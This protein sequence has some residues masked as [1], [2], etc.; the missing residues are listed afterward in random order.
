VAKYGASGVGTEGKGSSTR[1]VDIVGDEVHM[2]DEW[3]RRPS[4]EGRPDVCSR[5]AT[6]KMGEG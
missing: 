4:T 6:E 1:S 5:K 2:L 3:R